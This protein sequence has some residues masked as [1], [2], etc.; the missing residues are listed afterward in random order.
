MPE[1]PEIETI[2]LQISKIIIGKRIETISIEK[3][4]SFIGDPSLT[5]N[6]KIKNIRRFAKILVIDFSNNIS[7]AVHL[8]MSGQ[9]LFRSENIEVR[10]KNGKLN[11]LPDKHTRVIIT[12]TD[13]DKL[14]FNDMR[15]FGWLRVLKREDLSNIVGKLGPDAL[16]EL[17]EKKFYEIL[18]SS[19]RPIKLVLM[20]QEKIAGVGNIYANDALFLSRI[21]PKMQANKLS[22]GQIVKLLGSIKRVLRDGIKWKGASRNNFRDIYGEKGNVQDHFWVYDRLGYECPNKCGGKIKKIRLGGRGTFF[23]VNCQKEGDLVE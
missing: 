6:S 19:K 2:R 10:I 21:D 15:I 20:D 13:G 17:D 1:L 5:Y 7:L 22:N 14:F 18:N 12:F 3:K 16:N 9:L 4:K 23:C 8:K 11:N